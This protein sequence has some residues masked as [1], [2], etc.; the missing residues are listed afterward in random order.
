[1]EHNAIF[2]LHA[3]CVPLSLSPP[4]ELSKNEGAQKVMTAAK[5]RHKSNPP[6]EPALA[7]G[8]DEPPTKLG[9]GLMS[10]TGATLLSGLVRVFARRTVVA[11]D[12]GSLVVGIGTSEELKSD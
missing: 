10:G 12:I 3:C 6:S 2:S 1:M 4:I 11:E 7:V 5:I 9:A 8:T